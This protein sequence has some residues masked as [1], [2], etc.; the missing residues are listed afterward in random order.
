MSLE[1]KLYPLLSLYDRLPQ[2]ARNFIGAAYRRLPRRIRYGR[3]Y[4]EFRELAEASPSWSE[5]DLH[6]YQLRELRRTLVNAGSYCPF[7]SRSF[8]KAGFR[9][10]TMMS[11]DDLADCPSLTK[12]DI[13]QHFD[14]LTSAE[15]ADAKKLYMT[16]GG[17]TGVPVGFHLQK[18]VS[19][20]KEQ[21]FLE[22]N[23]RRAGYFD[24]ARVA[25][26]RGHVT[27]SRSRGNIIAHDA[28]RNWLMLSSYHL[29]DER[30]PEYLEM[31][32]NFQPD[33]LNIYPSAALQ[34]ADYLQRH[35]QRWR[36]PLQ[37]VLCGSEQLTLSQ[38]RLL[39]SVFKC[40]VLRWYGHAE[41]VVLAAEGTDSDLF[42]FW[43]HY[44]FVEFGKPD[45]NG[46]QEVIGTT[47]HNMAMPLVRYRTG[48]F[49]RLAKPEARR[50]YA[51][52][53]VE[54]I[55]GRRQEFLVTGSGRRISLTAFNMHDA[56][57][58]GLYAV[59]FFQ[60]EQ[61]VA[62]FRYIPSPEFHSSRLPQIEDGI[63]RKLG[64]D[65]RLVLRKVGEVEK[66]SRGKHTWLISRL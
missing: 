57:F 37:G 35:N 6:E 44:G 52:P 30:I 65:F 34:L 5:S 9:P 33:F 26:I 27:D 14:D 43:P 23:W 55:A 49:V 20:P 19:R 58:D 64:D 54:E 36:T 13:Q 61:G 42:Y 45:E 62:E 59:Q 17:S 18:G 21:A 10:D 11:L 48:D 53:A 29:T 31:L 47:F 63:R 40:R 41:R 22:A 25:L 12:Q 7:Y 56:I 60:S 16:T 3:A 24:K 46:L 2:R 15:I 1:D 4:S 28:T 8:A 50:E 39:N 32:E 38:K 51:W 66:T